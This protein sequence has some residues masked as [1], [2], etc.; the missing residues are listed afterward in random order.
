MTSENIATNA[1][2]YQRM[3]SELTVTEASVKAKVFPN[4][5][6]YYYILFL[7]T[8]QAGR[9]KGLC[10]SLVKE[11]QQ[12]ARE[13]NNTPIYL[14]AATEYCWKLYERLGFVTVQ[15]MWLGVGKAGSDGTLVD[16]GKGEGYKIWGMVWRPEMG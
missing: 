4:N 14:E 10:S 11:Y 16:G 12:I 13:D 1:G 7:G 9:R 2:N 15:E 8:S 6:P 5:E 3:I